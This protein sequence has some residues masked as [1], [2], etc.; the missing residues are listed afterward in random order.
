MTRDDAEAMAN[1][2]VAR[3][4]RQAE[5]L[6]ADL[7]ALLGRGRSVAEVAAPPGRP[8]APRGRAR[9]V[10]PDRRLRRP[11]RARG[12]P[13]SGG[14]RRRRSCARCATTSAGTAT[15]S[16]CWRRSSGAWADACHTG[17]R[18]H[19]RPAHRDPPAE[20]R[21]AR[22][23]RRRAR[24]RRERRRPPRRLRPVRRGTVPGDRV[25]R[26]GHQ[27]QA[28]LRRGAA[29][30]VLEPSPERIAPVADHPG[31]P[32]QVLR[33]RAPAR[34]QAGAGRRRAAAHRQARRLRARAD[35]PRR[36]GVALP[37]Q[38]RVLLR[39]A[40]TAGSSAASTRPARGSGSSR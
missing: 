27:A 21:G 39:H 32:W 15:A 8:R 17:R 30:E 14:P 26:G 4:R 7:D 13:P 10:V 25:A 33:L 20:G 29:L 11:R 40:T 37:Q 36:A 19:H 3:G 22:A 9:V 16:R 12:H 28:R 18:E 38:G 34:G 23:A 1:D 35:R 2:L 5:D 24:P 6:L 31:A